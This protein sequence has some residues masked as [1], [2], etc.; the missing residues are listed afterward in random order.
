MSLL[1]IP[2]GVTKVGWDVRPPELMGV[3]EMWPCPS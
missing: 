1:S 3:A 2:V